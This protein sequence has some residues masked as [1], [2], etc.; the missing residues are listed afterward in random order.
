MEGVEAVEFACV[1][2][3][4]AENLVFAEEAELEGNGSSFPAPPM[5]VPL[6]F[7]SFEADIFSGLVIA[8]PLSHLSHGQG[9]FAAYLYAR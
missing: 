2:S 6:E 1:F 4:I 9:A 8:H 3:L 7:P 5:D